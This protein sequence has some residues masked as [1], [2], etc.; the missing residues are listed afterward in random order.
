MHKI[1]VG[2]DTGSIEDYYQCVVL[3]VPDEMDAEELEQ[4]LRD[5][6][7]QFDQQTIVTWEDARDA[8]D[9]AMQAHNIGPAVRASV[10]ATAF[11]G[12][13]NAG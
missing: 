9:L 1:I 6:F 4:R 11:D 2:T 3:L 12:L 13:D 8:F 10:I 5:D 7:F